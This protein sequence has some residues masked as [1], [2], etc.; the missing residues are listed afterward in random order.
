LLTPVTVIVPVFNEEAMLPAFL[1]QTENWPV[2]EMIIVDGNSDDQ[3]KSIIVLSPKNLL[4]VA[5][6]GRGNQMNE[7]AK[8]ATGDILLFLH[9]DSIFPPD[10]FSEIENWVKQ[11]PDIVGGAFRLKINSNSRFL[12]FIAMMA[13]IRSSL[14][15]L[16]Y[17][18][19][20]IFVRREIF[21]K[22]G[23]YRDLPLMEDVE[24][25]RRL[26]RGGKIVLLQQA[27]TTSA[28]RW[29]RQGIFF[30]SIRNI[31]L[32]M[33]YLMGVSPKRLA[34]WYD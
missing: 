1:H 9:A 25:I 11:N 19:Q 34:K 20:G 5:K 6:K 26:K 17:G 24:F 23:G 16:P 4:L 33:L 18:D 22:M 13:N 32:L 15:G 31:I 27:I 10:G 7:G 30:A 8:A 12:K 21:N 2:R 29:N 14:F 28:R 3:T